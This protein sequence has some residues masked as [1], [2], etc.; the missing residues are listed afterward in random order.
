MAHHDKMRRQARI[1]AHVLTKVQSEILPLFFKGY[2]VKEIAEMRGC[3][4]K[5][6]QHTLEDLRV[7]AG[8]SNG[9]ELIYEAFRNG[10]LTAPQKYAQVADLVF[11]RRNATE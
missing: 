4:Y 10:W 5:T 1:D 11:L 7:E 9:R 2:E 6:V 8:V 3:S